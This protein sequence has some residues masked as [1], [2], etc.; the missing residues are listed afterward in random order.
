MIIILK[1]SNKNNISIPITFPGIGNLVTS[2]INTP[3][4]YIPKIIIASLNN[5]IF[6]LLTAF[7]LVFY[8][9]NDDYN[10]YFSLSLNFQKIKITFLHFTIIP[11]NINYIEKE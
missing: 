6:S 7:I 4:R 3:K 11:I 5:F 2:A 1:H 8:N 10:I 9:Y